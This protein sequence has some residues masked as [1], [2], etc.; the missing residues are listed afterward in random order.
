MLAIQHLF[1]YSKI[2]VQLV[3]FLAFSYSISAQ[4]TPVHY[5]PGDDY[6]RT[7]QLQGKIGAE[8]SLSIR[9]ISRPFIL[10]SLTQVIPK[11]ADKKIRYRLLPVTGTFRYNSSRPFGWNDA[12]MRMASGFQQQWSTGVYGRL[13]PLELQLQPEW[14][15][16][17]DPIYKNTP[18][19]G[20]TVSQPLSRF[21]PGQS[22]LQVNIWPIAFGVSTRNLWWGPAQFSALLMSNHA[23]GFPHAYFQS[24]RP[25]RTPI[26]HFEWQLIGAVLSEDSSRAMENAA[27]RPLA[28]TSDKRYLNAFV[29]SYHPRWLKGLYLGFSRTEQSYFSD[30]KSS[31]MPFFKKY[32]STLRITTPTDNWNSYY[33]GG[34]SSDGLASFFL[35]WRMEKAKAELYTEFGYN[36]F[37]QNLRDLAVNPG[38][39]AAYTL[40][41]KKVIE[42]NKILWDLSAELTR[43]SQSNSYLLRNAGN[44]YTHG[45]PAQG[46]T[47]QNQVLGGGSG[48]GNNLQT[49]Q[50]L[51]R[52]DFNYWGIR[53][54][55]IQQDPKG[56]A[57]SFENLGMRTHAWTDWV[58]GI[59]FQQRYRQFFTK[60]EILAV[61]ARNFG[62]AEED[63]FNLFAQIQ[64]GY[65][66]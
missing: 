27:L 46:Y 2:L 54:Q 21:Y 36:D 47:H 9:P 51:R 55:R 39:A 44:W 17:A 66:W 24:R 49:L 32:F 15:Q 7:A 40:G 42:Q 64:I 5:Q 3:C 57:G 60:G 19:Y 10:D 56:L 14:V 25:L 58:A 31:G 35:R 12:A 61:Q 1:R 6:L 59:L 28:L 4:F 53:L 22:S 45:R 30:I 26:G 52:K 11:N 29:L 43:M 33:N 62:W 23:S 50:L 34:F 13:G 41:F 38:H 18:A 63:R 20:A 8:Y 48:L 16:L 65:L 37:K